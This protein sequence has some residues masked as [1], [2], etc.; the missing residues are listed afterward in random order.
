V[1]PP[2]PNAPV[3][4]SY[5]SFGVALLRMFSKRYYRPVGAE[6]AV[7]TR[8]TTSRINETIDAS[9]FEKWRGN[10]AY[11]PPNLQA[12][13]DRHKVDPASM[14]ETVLACN[15]KVVVGLN[16]GLPTS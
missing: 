11:R 5:A 16:P 12:W 2:D 7:G 1:D 15:P 14:T 9:V 10:P 6:P 13:A 3:T 4:D 8:R